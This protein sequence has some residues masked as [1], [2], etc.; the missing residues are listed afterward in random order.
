[1]TLIRLCVCAVPAVAVYA[2]LAY[3]IRVDEVRTAAD[4]LKALAKR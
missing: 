3:V 2:A 4:R 1:M